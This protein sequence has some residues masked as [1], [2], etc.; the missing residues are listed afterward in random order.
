MW[1]EQ[2]FAGKE[3]ED[4]IV[5]GGGRQLHL[6][7]KLFRDYTTWHVTQWPKIK[8]EKVPYSAYTIWIENAIEDHLK[9]LKARQRH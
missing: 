5:H 1:V 7:R 2:I 9:Q 6:R 3:Y 4:Y 8:D